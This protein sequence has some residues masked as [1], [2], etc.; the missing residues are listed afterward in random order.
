MI[1][2]LGLSVSLSSGCDMCTEE[3]ADVIPSPDGKHTVRIIL[4]NCGATVSYGTAIELY[5]GDEK[6]NDH[7]GTLFISPSR[8]AGSKAA[9]KDNNHLFIRYSSEADVTEMVVELDGVKVEY[10]VD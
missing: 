1:V 6:S 2:I 8:G 5:R 10:E 3:E 9:W 7:V 4:T